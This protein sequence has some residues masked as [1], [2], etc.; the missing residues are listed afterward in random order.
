M[1]PG[2]L[3]L[4]R[5]ILSKHMNKPTQIFKQWAFLAAVVLASLTMVRGAAPSTPQGFI[6]GKAFYNVPGTTIGELVN[7]PKFPDTPDDISVF[8]H[9]EWAATDD[10]S[11][12]PGN[13]G[14]NYGGQIVGYFYPPSTG[15]YLFW[16]SADDNA[17]LYLSTDEDPANKKLIARETGWSNARE[18]DMTSGSSDVTAKSSAEF[19]G[20]EWADTDPNWGGAIINLTKGKA[21]YIEALFNEGGG[22]DNL[23]VAVLDPNDAIDPY[24]PIPGDYLSSDRVEGPVSIVAQPS[25]ASADERGSATFGVAINGTPPYEAQWYRDGVA[26]DGATTLSLVVDNV[27]AADDGAQF[28]VQISGAQGNVTSEAATLTVV[29]DTIPPSLLGA[30]GL[31]S[32]TEIILSFSEGMNTADAEN[33]S[34]YKVN[35]SSGALNVTSATLSPSGASVTLVTAKQTLGKKYTILVSNL[36]DVAAEPNTI[37]PNSKGVIVPVG[38]LQQIDGFIV[39]EAE[40]YDRNLDGLWVPDS[41]RGSA[42]GGISMV[43]PN[44]GG[45]SEANTRLEYDITFPEDAIY[46]VWYRASGDNGNDD[47]GWLYIDDER[48]YGR[49]SGNSASM[50]GFSGQADFVWR[51]DSQDGPDPYTIDVLAGDAVFALA[52]REDGSFFDKFILTTDM[53]FQPTGAGPAETRAGVPAAPT[54][55]M[56]EPSGQTKASAGDTISFAATAG[57]D[58]EIEVARVDFAVNGE[59]VASATQSPYTASW[60]AE[61]GIFGVTATVVDEIGQ[62]VTTD[63]VTLVV[64]ASG[65]S[66]AANIA[67]VSFHPADDTPSNAAGAAGYTAAPDVEYT[68]MITANGHKITRVLTGPNPDVGVLNAYDLV[69]ISRSVSS[70]DYSAADATAA[71]NGIESPMLILGGYIMR[72]SRLGLT[73][74]TT[75]VDTVGPIQL[76]IEDTS[77]P[78]FEGIE[79]DGS[80]VMVNDYAGVME[81]QGTVERGISVNNNDLAGEGVVLASSGTFDDPTYGGPMIAE[82]KGGD[83]LANGSEDTLAGPRM[84]LLTGSREH[85]GLTAEGSGIYDISEDGA[86]ILLNAITY[87]TGKPGADPEAPEPTGTSIAFVS[88]HETDEPSS[89][90]AGAGMTEAADIGYTDALQAAGHSVTRVLTSAS[91]DV[92]TLNAYDLVII[93]RSVPSGNYSSGANADNWNSVQAPTLLLGGWYLRSSRMGYTDG[94]TM[95]D[96]S[97]MIQLKVED[98]SHPLF[99]GINVDGNGVTG[100]FADVLTWNGNLQRGIS[101]NNNNVAGNG[102]VLATVAT[103]GDS[104]EGGFIAAEWDAGSATANGGTFAGKR[105]VLLTG[106]R[107][108]D[109]VTSETAGIYDLTDTGKQIFLNAVTYLTSDGGGNTGGGSVSSV[110]LSG[111]NVVVEYT[112]TLKSATSVTGPYQA[113][114]GA[115]SPYTV[116]PSKAAEF[117]IA[118]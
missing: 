80:G 59:V 67:W 34:N 33:V 105:M 24:L 35:S 47:S 66:D 27:S 41:E 76:Q 25:N 7:H 111:G 15:E 29:P 54:V 46:R 72:S 83:L 39:F 28:T 86:Q 8:P 107:E 115:S 10:I 63:S 42:S 112:G 18:Y 20:T 64:S 106:S 12:P 31:P 50:T 9:F 85:S 30:K 58:G 90:A 71:W 103:A 116:T 3:R 113:V 48:P 95:V 68:Q 108:A 92:N 73:T 43:V 88:F 21:Y 57:A 69:I 65:S 5:S 53:D 26:I 77:H 74:G 114:A 1:S 52:R 4:L 51:S 23:S 62:A 96:T 22:G 99:A 87:L 16:I 98:A 13:Q 97:G 6:T 38:G 110:S 82:W 14:D 102:R 55:T 32:L 89:A 45:G 100:D 36:K 11:T 117:Y 37:E 44:G 118:E 78:I 19:T 109:G 104:A 70:G 94:T 81:F 93:S 91:P 61:E 40:N 101:V 2:F 84:V 17:E 49:E 75:M 56:T 60:S 79:L